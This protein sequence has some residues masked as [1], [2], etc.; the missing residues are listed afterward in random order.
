MKSSRTRRQRGE[1]EIGGDARKLSFLVNG[2]YFSGCSNADETD[3]HDTGGKHQ[4][5]DCRRSANKPCFAP[6]RTC[7]KHLTSTWESMCGQVLKNFSARRERVGNCNEQQIGQYG[8]VAVT[9]D[10]A[11][12]AELCSSRAIVNLSKRRDT[13]VFRKS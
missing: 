3:D 12:K 2:F 4:S 11:A 7:W 5:G 1:K 10:A 13:L 8:Q 6:I 9:Y